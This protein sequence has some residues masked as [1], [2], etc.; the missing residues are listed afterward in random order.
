MLTFGS[1]CSGI[2]AA[3]IAWEPLGFKPLWFSEIES[4][5]SAVLDH[6][7]PQIPNLGDMTK[8]HEK[9]TK[10]EQLTPDVLVGGTPCQSFSIAGPREGLGDS[11]GQ[12]SL[13]YIEL[14]NVI[15]EERKKSGKKE[16]IIVWENV[17]GVLSSKDNAFGQFIGKLAGESVALQPAGR[18]WTNVGYV[19]G[20][21]RNVAWRILDAQYFGVAQRRRRLFVVASARAG[22][23]PRKVLFESESM[24]RDIAQSRVEGDSIAGS[25]RTRLARGKQVT[26]PLL[27]NCGQKQWLGNQEAFSGD[28]R[29]VENPTFCIANNTINRSAKNGGNGKGFQ[30]EKSY[31]LDTTS[32]HAVVYSRLNRAEIETH[33]N[34]SPT[35][36]ARMGT[37]G[38]NVPG[39]ISLGRVRR[40]TPIECERLQGFFDNFTKVPY[41]MKN[42]EDCPDSPRYK[43]LGNSMAVPVMHWIGRR[44]IQ[45]LD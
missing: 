7:W 43:A 12:L 32:P 28:Y 3:S 16:S 15:D 10:G 24:P 9:I 27:A 38:G 42:K 19:S 22:F 18:K 36:T 30:Q 26:G 39:V 25:S 31:T 20:P 8:I 14:A 40:L 37:G 21:K 45:E 29:I 11:R 5:P 1:V 23:D 33:S 34:L 41:R 2:E 4:F 6:H 44:I 13:S 17:P 35:L